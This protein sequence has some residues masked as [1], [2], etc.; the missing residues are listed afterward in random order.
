MD[1]CWLE[2]MELACS[3][4][5]CELIHPFNITTWPPRDVHPS[6]SLIAIYSCDGLLQQVTAALDASQHV[7]PRLRLMH[8][9]LTVTC[10][11]ASNVQAELQVPAG[12]T[13]RLMQRCEAV[14]LKCK[15]HL[16]DPPI[17][18]IRAPFNAAFAGS[19][20]CS[21]SIIARYQFSI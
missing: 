13:E 11:D 15:Q 14:H 12:I 20:I 1:C 17:P 16:R 3:D 5:Q 19:A 6:I 21:S 9:A 10:Q 7:Q 2:Y 18:S 8:N 4:I